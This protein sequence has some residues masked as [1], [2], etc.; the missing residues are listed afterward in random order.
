MGMTTPREFENKMLNAVESGDS[1]I[2]IAA[3]CVKV[4]LD[5][6]D[7]LGYTEGVNIFKE[8]VDCMECSRCK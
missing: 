1:N 2:Q 5:T 8:Y 7:S 4:M 3:L 6:L